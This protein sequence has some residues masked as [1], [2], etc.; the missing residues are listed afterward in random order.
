MGWFYR[1]RLC[2]TESDFLIIFSF[3][4]RAWSTRKVVWS[5]DL[6]QFARIS[7]GNEE[8][9]DAIPMSEIDMVMSMREGRSIR[10]KESSMHA[11][12]TSKQL[13]SVSS[14]R[15]DDNH[16]ILQIKTTADG[17]NSGR[18]Y[19][20]RVI[21][22]NPKLCDE[23]IG[24]LLLSSQAARKKQVALSQF[25]RIQCRARAIHDSFG[26][27]SFVALLI[28]VVSLPIHTPTLGPIK[29]HAQ[30]FQRCMLLE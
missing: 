19:Y 20:L 13:T 16:H 5:R 25:K 27:Q 12:T 15:G 22:D 21:E 7:D 28:C 29:L 23:I 26:F 10:T 17:Y 6:I 4:F 1:F 8:V 30:C 11:S 18:T 14:S 9:V 24:K 3:V 2:S